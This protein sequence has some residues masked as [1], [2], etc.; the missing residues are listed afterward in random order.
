[1]VKAEQMRDWYRDID[2]LGVPG[3]QVIGIDSTLDQTV[4]R[5]LTD[6]D[7]TGGGAIA[8]PVED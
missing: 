3:E 7:W 5:I 1:M 4:A 2:L 8:H 6:L